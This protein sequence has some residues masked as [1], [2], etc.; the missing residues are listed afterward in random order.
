MQPQEVGLGEV[1]N[2]KVLVIDS[3]SQQSP[4][5]GLVGLTSL[6]THK[7]LGLARVLSCLLLLCP[8]T[9]FGS[10]GLHQPANLPAVPQ[11]NMF[12]ARR[13][14]SKHSVHQP[15][16]GKAY[17]GI[18]ARLCLTATMP[19]SLNILM[20]YPT[21]SEKQSTALLSR[22]TVMRLSNA[23]V[24]LFSNRASLPTHPLV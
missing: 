13:T 18:P 12:H 9:T 19:H 20:R 1:E 22:V 21:C 4:L 8:P 5:Q 15:A 3:R 6:S 16:T 10:S 7:S 17:R 11:D 24:F 2:L 14:C 23:H